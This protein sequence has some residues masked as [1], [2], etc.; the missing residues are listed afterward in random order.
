[1][2]AVQAA[3]GNP[4]GHAVLGQPGGQQLRNVYDTVLPRGDAGN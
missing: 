2:D 4:S 1:V 3:G